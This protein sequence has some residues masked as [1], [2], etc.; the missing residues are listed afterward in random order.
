MD[1]VKYSVPIYENGVPTKYSVD[2]E[3]G[4]DKHKQLMDLYHEIP[5]FINVKT[6]SDGKERTEKGIDE[7]QGNG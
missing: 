1:K 6:K 7:D 5:L 2:F 3:E 4:D